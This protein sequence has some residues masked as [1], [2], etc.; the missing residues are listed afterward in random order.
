MVIGALNK[1]KI[2][3]NLQ[4][5]KILS[6]MITQEK[7]LSFLPFDKFIFSELK[8][9]VSIVVTCVRK[10]HAKKHG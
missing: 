6:Q 8:L 10:N 4:R 5:L 3:S 1:K 9:L 2:I 7:G